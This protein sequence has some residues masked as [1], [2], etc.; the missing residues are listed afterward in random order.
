MV[1]A[2]EKRT[3]KHCVAYPFWK[4]NLKAFN[5]E[6]GSYGWSADDVYH[7]SIP[8]EIKIVLCSRSTLNGNSAENPFNFLNYQLN[9]AEVMVDGVSVPREIFLKLTGP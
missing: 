6:K 4:S 5:I 1:V 8:S 2:H 7:G 9:F 3:S